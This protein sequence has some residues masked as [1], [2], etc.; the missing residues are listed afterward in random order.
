[1]FPIKDVTKRG[2]HIFP[3]SLV[4]PADAAG[5]SYRSLHGVCAYAAAA[6]QLQ[7]H[8][9]ATAAAAG[10][11]HGQCVQQQQQST[12]LKHLGST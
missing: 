7:L 5:T 12:E 1:M 9:P 4:L 10:A 2:M 3:L 6:G 8:A 11:G